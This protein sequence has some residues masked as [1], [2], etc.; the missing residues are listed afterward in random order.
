[1]TI[2]RYYTGVGSRETPVKIKQQMGYM[3][4]E[5]ARNGYILRSGGANG[6]DIAFQ[7]GCDIG[8]T[9]AKEIY[10]PWASYGPT[11]DVLEMGIIVPKMGKKLMGIL[12]NIHPNYENLSVQ[13]K[14]LHGRNIFQVIGYHKPRVYSSFLL[15]WTPD[16]AESADQCS[17]KTGGTATAIRMAS[18]LKI[19]IFNFK[20]EDSMHKAHLLVRLIQ[21]RCPKCS[22]RKN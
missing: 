14:K 1:M 5:L 19:P 10:I 20:N 18:K 2:K 3:A 7:R 9:R 15:C 8:N 12:K 21:A 17:I 13:A 4:C 22:K 6:A 16:G 11:D